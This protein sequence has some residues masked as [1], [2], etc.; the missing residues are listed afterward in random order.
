MKIPDLPSSS[1][2]TGER[3]RTQL[4]PVDGSTKDNCALSRQNY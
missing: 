1:Q 2:C 4:L 3:G